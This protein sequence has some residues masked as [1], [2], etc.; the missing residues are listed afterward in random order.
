MRHA[1]PFICLFSFV[2]ST[3]CS[4]QAVEN[5]APEFD[6]QLAARLGA[7]DYGM[8]NYVFALLKTGPAD[9]ADPQR[10][11]RRSPVISKPGRWPSRT[12]GCPSTQ[13]FGPL[14]AGLCKYPGL[15]P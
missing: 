10:V 2:V 15:C 9:T 11:T 12:L 8:R 14:R 3:V 5:Q 7:D 6:S 1:I 4:E 13:P